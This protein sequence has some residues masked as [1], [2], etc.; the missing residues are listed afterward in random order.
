LVVLLHQKEI[1]V[2]VLPQEVPLVQ[3]V[4]A[5]E[6][7]QHLCQQVELEPLVAM[8]LLHQLQVFLLHL[9]LV[10][11]EVEILMLVLA[12]MVVV[13]LLVVETQLLLLFLEP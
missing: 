7:L 13:E 6:V 4:V 9:L 2:V 10:E 11:V 5:L 3:V 1:T 12:V 8:V